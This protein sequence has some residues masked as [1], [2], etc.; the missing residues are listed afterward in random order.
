MKRFRFTFG[1]IFGVVCLLCI[2]AE[3]YLKLTDGVCNQAVNFTNTT[4]IN[5]IAV[6]SQAYA[7]QQSRYFTGLE[8]VTASAPSSVTEGGKSIISYYTYSWGWTAGSGTLSAIDDYLTTVYRF[9]DGAITTDSQQN[10]TLT[11]NGTVGTSTGKSGD[12]AGAFGSGKS[13]SRSVT[14]ASNLYPKSTGWSFSCWIKLTDTGS[15]SY[16]YEV[17]D[18]STQK[19]YLK[20][21]SGGTF[22]WLVRDSGGTYRQTSGSASPGTTNFNN[23]VC[24]WDGSDLKVYFNGSQIGSSTACASIDTAGDVC[25]IGNSGSNT[26]LRGYVDEFYVWQYSLDSDDVTALYESNTGA[27]RTQSTI[28]DFRPASNHIFTGWHRSPIGFSRTDDDTIVVSDSTTVAEMFKVGRPIR[29]AD[30]VGTWRYGIVTA[31]SSGTID[32]AGGALTTDYDTYI[33]IGDMSKAVHT[34]FFISGTYGD[35]ADTDLLYNDG[36]TKFLWRLGKSYGVKISAMHK[37]VDTGTEPKINV[38]VNNA[39]LSTDDSNNGIQLSTAG[40][41]VD[42]SSTGINTSNYDINNGEEIEIECT[43]AGGTGDASDLTVDV[44]FIQE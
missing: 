10:D 35:G 18:G 37:T 6:A 40:T 8:D 13:L 31:Y 22:N 11:N 20:W 1:V 25:R 41:F 29:Y 33:E 43:V 12:A 17:T 26:Y 2:G 38:Q 32:L 34:P 39:K 7:S 28:A 16:I 19:A 3:T 9:E 21:D 30:T 14:S 23:L 4:T 36:N 44:I 24:T 27:F 42:N 15:D 5:G